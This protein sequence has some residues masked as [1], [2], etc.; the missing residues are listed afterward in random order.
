MAVFAKKNVILATVRHMLKQGISLFA[1]FS[2]KS[3]AIKTKGAVKVI[4]NK[5]NVSVGT[6]HD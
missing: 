4:A 2:I 6:Y 1:V 3:F 5:C